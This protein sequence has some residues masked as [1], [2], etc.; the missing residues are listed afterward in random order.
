MSPQSFRGKDVRLWKWTSP[1]LASL[2]CGSGI[3]IVPTGSIEQHGPHLPLETDIRNATEFAIRAATAFNERSEGHFVLVA[4]PLW[5]GM[6][7]HHWRFPGTMSLK[8]ETLLGL[9]ADIVA[10]LRHTGFVKMLILNGHGA[11]G[12]AVALAGMRAFEDLGVSIYS[13]SYWHLISQEVSQVMTSPLGGVSHACE[14]ETSLALWLYPDLVRRESIPERCLGDFQDS[15]FTCTDFRRVGPVSLPRD[16]GLITDA[17]VLGDPG[18]A[19]P[20]K[21]QVLAEAVIRAVLS[22][23]Q[24]IADTPLA[25]L[26]A[27]LQ[28]DPPRI[29]GRGQE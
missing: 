24:E 26:D 8:S 27:A 15:P 4:P 19:T 1:E 25:Q 10:S 13:A 11:N 7:H 16:L 21:G 3:V 28:P 6:S 14:M 5:W 2:D 17:G 23:L 12:P 22:L 20:E 29:T 18:A 9:L